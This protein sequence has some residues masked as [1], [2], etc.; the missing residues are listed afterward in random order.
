MRH[1]I[2]YLRQIVYHRAWG[3]IKI[4]DM[5]QGETTGR[6]AESSGLCENRP[7]INSDCQV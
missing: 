6:N 5:E 7:N 1:P 2:R 4:Q 3:E